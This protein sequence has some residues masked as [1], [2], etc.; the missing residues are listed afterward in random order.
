MTLGAVDFNR[1]RGSFEQVIGLLGVPAAWSEAIAPNAT[2][3]L[4]IGFRTAGREDTEVINA[5]GPHSVIMTFAA[6]DMP[7]APVKFDSVE[8]R[9]TRYTL[10]AVHPIHLNG[11]LIGWKA[12]SRGVDS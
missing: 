3:N 12:F 11:S 5:Y 2:A 7:Q 4:V 1:V 10:D 9:G 8:I 6:K